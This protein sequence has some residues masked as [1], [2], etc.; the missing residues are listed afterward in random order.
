MLP[1]IL[2]PRRSSSLHSLAIHLGDANNTRNILVDTQTFKATENLEAALKNLRD[3]KKSFRFWVDAICI[4]QDDDDEKKHQLR[5]MPTIF[6]RVRETRVWLGPKED[7]SDRAINLIR[8]LS[9]HHVEGSA[10][11]DLTK[12]RGADYVSA[13]GN[14]ADLIALQHLFIR[15]YWFRVWV[16]QEIAMSRNVIISCGKCQLPW[17]SV[18]N[19]TEFMI[20]LITQIDSTI[21][22]YYPSPSR[23]A[24]RRSLRDGMQ[25]ILS[26][27]SARNDILE[28]G[29][30]TKRPPDSLLFLLSSHR[31]TEA[32]EA[33]DKYYALAGLISEDDSI[34]SQ[35]S[36][37]KSVEEIYL[38]S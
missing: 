2:R 37:A 10:E 14:E 7:D 32:T 12:S 24:P 5:F 38:G 16:V 29:D 21:Y 13:P 3:G 35:T 4:K 30:P 22:N 33:R 36:S 20:P 28:P 27:Q 19:A 1:R 25:R 34:L 23:Y 6:S 15:N 17:D 31:P 26:I 9:N 8:R 11:T 18:A